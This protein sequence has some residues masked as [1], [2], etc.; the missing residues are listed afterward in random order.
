MNWN[1]IFRELYRL[2]LKN[3]SKNP[4]LLKKFTDG[5]N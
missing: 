4:K 3:D 2:R 5:T 1:L